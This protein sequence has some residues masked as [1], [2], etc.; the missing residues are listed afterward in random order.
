MQRHFSQ[1][2]QRGPSYDA[3]DDIFEIILTHQDVGVEFCRNSDC[4]VHPPKPQQWLDSLSLEE[5]R[6]LAQESQNVERFRRLQSNLAAKFEDRGAD[7]DEA[8]SEAFSVIN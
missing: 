3:D 2:G 8:V 7:W 1:R 4:P 6:R 5:R